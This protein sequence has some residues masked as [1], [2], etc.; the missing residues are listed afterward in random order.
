MF[1]FL[2]ILDAN[3]IAQPG[4]G[5]LEPVVDCLSLH[6]K[7]TE[8][9]TL[10]QIVGNTFTS[11]S[12]N[13]PCSRAT[14]AMG[15]HYLFVDNPNVEHREEYVPCKIRFQIRVETNRTQV[16]EQK[17]TYTTFRGNEQ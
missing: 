8:K 3:Y 2:A 5:L 9:Q 7:G 12:C 15:L 13:V 17:L 6:G 4:S 11:C 1:H 16:C 14:E 10:V